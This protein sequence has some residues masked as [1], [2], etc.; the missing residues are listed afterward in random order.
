[1]VYAGKECGPRREGVGFILDK[2]STKSIIGYN[3]MIPRGITIRLK[4]HP[5][6]LTIIQ[7]YAPTSDASDEDLE[8]FYNT[9]Q[10]ALDKTPPRDLLV[11]MGDWNAKWERQKGRTLTYA[12]MAWAS[13][14]KEE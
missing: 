4:A 5:I 1:M 9:V 8:S 6:N 10:E 11:M 3:P 13:K 2:E 14:T 12:S 7:V